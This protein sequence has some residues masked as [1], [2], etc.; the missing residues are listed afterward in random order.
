MIYSDRPADLCSSLLCLS[1]YYLCMLISICLM[2]IHYL[3]MFIPRLSSGGGVGDSRRANYIHWLRVRTL[4][5]YMFI[6]CIIW[7]EV[8]SS[9]LGVP[10]IVCFEC[11]VGELE[12]KSPL[13]LG[14]FE[15]LCS[16]EPGK[17]K[18]G[19]AMYR[20]ATQS[21]TVQRKPCS[22]LRRDTTS[23]NP[24][25]KQL[26]SRTSTNR[27]AC[28]WQQLGSWTT[29]GTQGTGEPGSQ[30]PSKGGM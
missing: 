13:N 26:E 8:L 2:S 11:K 5:I 9:T 28:E 16:R 21:K 27:S 1:L 7:Q 19:K 23:R 12:V 17:V 22:F 24:R 18:R 15:H 4:W 6:I 29:R 25:L 14:P 10:V 3:Y 20:G 30:G